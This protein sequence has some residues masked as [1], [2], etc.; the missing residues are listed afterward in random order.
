LNIWVGSS[1][2]GRQQ[3]KESGVWGGEVR[4]YD[5]GKCWEKVR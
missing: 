1:N 3:E 2:P 5:Q 4:V